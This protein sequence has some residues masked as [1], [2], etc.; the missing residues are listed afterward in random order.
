MKP[1]DCMSPALRRRRRWW[2][3]EAIGED[4]VRLRCRSALG[5]PFQLIRDRNTIIPHLMS[6]ASPPLC[7]EEGAKGWSSVGYVAA[8]LSSRAQREPGFGLAVLG[9]PW[10]LLSPAPP[11]RPVRQIED[12]GDAD[13]AAEGDATTIMK[14][15]SSGLQHRETC[16]KMCCYSIK[17]LLLCSK[18]REDHCSIISGD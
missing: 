15:R 18:S 7:L 11:K 4:G 1:Q 2:K 5:Q 13:E 9:R 6:I 8:E 12:A 16:G 17:A 10:I 14:E 3:N